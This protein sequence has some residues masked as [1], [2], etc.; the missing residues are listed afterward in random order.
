M[1]L[2]LFMIITLGISVIVYMTRA[3]PFFFANKLRE[4]KL[5]QVL[6]RSLPLAIMLLLTSYE[7]SKST[8]LTP[9]LIGVAG[10]AFVHLLLKQPIIS[11]VTGTALYVTLIHFF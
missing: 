5:A 6:A 11:I 10:T 3:F 8:A 1:S 2:T 9:A 7:V 4:S